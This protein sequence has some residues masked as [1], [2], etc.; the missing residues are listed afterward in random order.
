M[1]GRIGGAVPPRSEW[2]QWR[3]IAELLDVRAHLLVVT[4]AHGKTGVQQGLIGSVTERF[5]H[6]LPCDVLAVRS[7]V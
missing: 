1:S 5:M 3:Q 7:M 2:R 6:A 4:G